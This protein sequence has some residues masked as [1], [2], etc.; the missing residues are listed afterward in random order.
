LAD[1]PADLRTMAGYLTL[2]VTEE[3][4]LPVAIDLVKEA[5]TLCERLLPGEFTS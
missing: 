4:K 5:R 3:F 2:R 1:T